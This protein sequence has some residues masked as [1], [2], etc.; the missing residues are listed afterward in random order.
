MHY[1]VIDRSSSTPAPREL[2][3]YSPRVTLAILAA[4]SIASWSLI[5]MGFRA[6]V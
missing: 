6:I 2:P 3:R 4:S 5:I 1:A